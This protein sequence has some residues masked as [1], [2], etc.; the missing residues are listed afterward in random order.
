MLEMYVCMNCTWLLVLGVRVCVCVYLFHFFG[1]SVS[2][3]SPF[4]FT[5]Y[6]H[7]Y[8]LRGRFMY[9]ASQVNFHC[10][11]CLLFPEGW[12]ELGTMDH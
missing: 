2:L 7:Y 9:S 1:L 8:P 12:V 5:H 3:L 11:L 10:L 4:S 6:Y